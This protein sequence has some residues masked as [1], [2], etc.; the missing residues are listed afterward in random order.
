MINCGDSK[1][2]AFNK[3]FKEYTMNV[4]I[5]PVHLLL[6]M[7]LVST[8]SD[9]VTRNPIYALV[10]IGFLIPAE[11]FI[12]EMFGLNKASS[13]SDFGS[14]AKNALAYEGL[15]KL[16]SSV[17]GGAKKAS[18]SIKG[19]S[20]NS[21]NTENA[22]FNKIRRA[23]LGSFAKNAGDTDG[24]GD[25]GGY[26][27]RPVLVGNNEQEENNSINSQN[28]GRIK[29]GPSNESEWIEEQKQKD[30]EKGY[31]LP[32]S[33]YQRGAEQWNKEKEEQEEKQRQE[34]EEQERIR[35]QQ[36]QQNDMGIAS[37]TNDAEAQP[38]TGYKRRI[39]AKAAK[40]I[41]KGVWKGTK[42]A[43]RGA[44]K[45]GLA[46]GGGTVGLASAISTGDVSNVPKYAL[47]GAY[48]GSALGNAVANIPGS[49]YNKGKDVYQ[50]AVNKYDNVLDSFND[51]MYGVSESKEKRNERLNAR[52][53]KNFLKDEN[54]IKKCTQMKRDIGF[55]GDI[56]DFMN[57][58]ADYK[59]AGVDDD[60]IKNALKVEHKRD[61]TIGG[62]NH[63]KMIDVAS[64]ATENGYKKADILGAKSRSDMEDVVQATIAE[65]DRYDV[66][67]SIADLYGQGDFYSKKSRFKQPNTNNRKPTNNKPPVNKG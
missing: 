43:A 9:L 66:M 67:K 56:K 6:Y 52:E 35:Q 16:G 50:S 38:K 64:F 45:T 63:N 24:I 2:Q 4:I 27:D 25:E 48:A 20:S 29:E 31:N 57:A 7:A 11:K 34:K 49:L 12:K 46:I 53:R 62:A 41:G 3:W 19:A 17:S 1:A 42:I 21:D 39:A 18:Q 28:E 54:Q 60:M 59:E 15:K 65:K 23:E 10:A 61:N 47:S 58:Y 51:E 32:D 5:Q 8:A 13:T 30:L 36:T 44:L 22:K 37:S 26:D 55:D 40:T 14:F 33:Y